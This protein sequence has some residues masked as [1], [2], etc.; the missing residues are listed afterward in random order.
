MISRL[1]NVCVFQHVPL[2]PGPIMIRQAM[3][4]QFPIPE[5]PQHIQQQQQQQQP[6]NG[7]IHIV[8][9]NEMRFFIFCFII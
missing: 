7:N 8:I 5:Q 6:I 4:H 1:K 3:V 2:G 9:V